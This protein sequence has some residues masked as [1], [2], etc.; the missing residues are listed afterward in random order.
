MNKKV[1]LIFALM[2]ILIFSLNGLANMQAGEEINWQVMS[3]GG[4]RGTSTNYVLSGTVGQTAVG[5]G[6]STAYAIN[7]G[8]WQPFS[9][10]SSCCIGV[11]ANV[12][13]SP[14]E[15]PDISDITRLIDF[16]YLSHNPLCCAEE[17]D[18]NVSGGDPDI[19]DITYI[20]D[21]LYL[22]HKALPACP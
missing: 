14:V 17:A 22:S 1:I 13:C 5:S 21:H 7:H 11:T 9:E 4:N 16:L 10:S 3:S 8:F 15:D 6:N 12:D 2:I 20:I 18:V 19:S